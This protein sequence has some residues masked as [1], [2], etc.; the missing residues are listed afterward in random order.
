MDLDIF[1]YKLKSL[2]YTK[3]LKNKKTKVIKLLE[4][5]TVD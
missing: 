1:Y 2:Y 4:S 5:N 3:K